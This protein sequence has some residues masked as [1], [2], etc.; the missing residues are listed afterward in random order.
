MY[1]F[2]A[3]LYFANAN[4]FRERVL[5]LI[6]ESK[7]PVHWFLWDAETITS[8]DSTAGQ[9]LLGL[10]REL[11]HR[12]ITFAVARLKGPIRSV[13][14]HTHRLNRELQH[15]PHYASI[16]DALEAYKLEQK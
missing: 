4:Y 9:M 12:D 11:K 15:S 6:D 8:I 1:R 5:S 14:H 3:P 13:V 7:E 10:I 16:G 2:D